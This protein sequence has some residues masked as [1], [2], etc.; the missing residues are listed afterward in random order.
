MANA[1][2]AGGDPLGRTPTHHKRLHR[3]SP[4]LS[5]PHG[6]NPVDKPMNKRREPHQYRCAAACSKKGQLRC[7]VTDNG[8]RLPLKAGAPPT[9][10]MRFS[11]WRKVMRPLL[12]S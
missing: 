1:P 6:V 12:R 5:P 2:K 10:G 7:P 4:V 11:M 9:R 3:A 8:Q